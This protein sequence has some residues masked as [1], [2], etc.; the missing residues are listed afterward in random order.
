MANPTRFT[1]LGTSGRT[2]TDSNTQDSF[3]QTFEFPIVLDATTSARDSGVKAPRT[4]QAMSA[5]LRITNAETVGTIKTV[6]VGVLGGGAASMI[7]A[8]DV[9]VSGVAGAPVTEAIFNN[10]LSNFSYSLGDVDFA[11]LEATVVLTVKGSD[12]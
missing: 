12:V 9:S 7:A 2:G 8:A 11:N 5:Y 4:I 3:T 10:S 1:K 6:S